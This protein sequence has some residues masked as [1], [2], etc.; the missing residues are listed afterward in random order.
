[1]MKT[2]RPGFASKRATPLLRFAL[3]AALAGCGGGGDWCDHDKW[4]DPGTPDPGVQKPPPQFSGLSLLAGDQCNVCTGS[5]NGTGSTAR[6]NGAEGIAADQQGNFYLAESIGATIRKIT[7]QGMVTTLAGSA[8]QTGNNDGAGT[9]ARFSNPTRVTVDSAGNVY[10]TDTGNST[11]RKISSTGAVT[12]IAGQPGTCGTQDGNGTQA[13]FCNPKGIAI[14]GS[15]N[16]FVSDTK[17]NTIRKIS[18]SG[19][20]ITLAGQAGVCGSAD[21]GVAIATFC[22]PGDITVDRWNNVYVADTA[23]STIRMIDPKGK[24]TTLAGAAGVCGAADGATGTSRLCSPGGITVDS[25]DNLYVSDTG[26][27]TIRRIDVNN[28]TTTVA[29]VPQQHGIILGPLPGGLDAPVGITMDTDVSVVLT[30]HNLVLRLL[31]PK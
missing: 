16:L 17:N 19:Q 9:A 11:I 2:S 26:N 10:V 20:V 18:P 23:N 13:L 22:Q 12:T 21:G 8:G 14:D 30:S 15:G 25:A 29:G 1:M 3:C 7:A 5:S 28:V 6:F 4:N 31:P 27:S 24:V